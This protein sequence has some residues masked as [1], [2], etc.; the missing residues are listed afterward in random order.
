MPVGET[1]F[2]V[3]LPR[4]DH[5]YDVPPVA[6]SDDDAPGQTTV[7]VAVAIMVGN[8]LTVRIT[9]AVL[10]HPLASVPVTL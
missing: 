6:A 10:T 4:L 2:G 9:E 5:K 1:V 3:P 7:G 8:E